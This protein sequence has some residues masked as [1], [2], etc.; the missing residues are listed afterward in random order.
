MQ[1]QLITFE[2]AKLA[3]E[4]GF[5]FDV[6]LDDYVVNGGLMFF[7]K[8]YK[9]PNYILPLNLLFWETSPNTQ[10]WIDIDVHC[11]TQSLLQ[12]WL[13]EVHN[14]DVE[15]YL[16][17]MTKNND[18]VVE[19]DFDMKDYTY[20][21]KHKGISQFAGNSGVKGSYEESLEVGLQEGLKL[22]KDELV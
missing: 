11:P 14:I 2:T 5:K 21:L 6:D 7:G 15:P 16:I 19:Q 22:I 9:D 13:R 12:K 20:F 4:K 3:K 8:N 17:V 10:Q 18:I 1:E